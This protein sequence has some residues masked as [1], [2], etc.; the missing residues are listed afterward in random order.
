ML[1]AAIAVRFRDGCRDRQRYLR[2]AACASSRAGQR[3]NLVR[4]SRSD[5][6]AAAAQADAALTLYMAGDFAEAL[7][8]V[9]RALGDVGHLP[10]KQRAQLH[11]MC[12]SA[13]TMILAALGRYAEARITAA[14]MKQVGNVTA[15]AWQAAVFPEFYTGQLDQALMICNEVMALDPEGNT[16]RISAAQIA[17]LLDDAAY[18]LR[19]LDHESDDVLRHLAIAEAHLHAGA[20]A[21][22]AD[23]LG[24][25]AGLLVELP[26]VMLTY[27]NLRA[28]T[29]ARSGDRTQAQASLEEVEAALVRAPHKRCEAEICRGQVHLWLGS[30]DEAVSS[31]NAAAASARHPIERH[32]ARYWLASAHQASGD[33]HHAE[34]TYRQVLGDQFR[35][36]MSAQARSMLAKQTDDH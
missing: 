26:A 32:I 29:Q 9:E 34:S 3:E 17:L 24:R 13:K 16:G 20:A 27:H 25:A 7:E 14:S 36:W 22:A 19:L 23:E 35:T 15:S 8:A 10:R 2:A 4:L 5:R 18:A 21:A 33:L 12:L 30:L 1:I 6:F 31:L 11:I 28:L